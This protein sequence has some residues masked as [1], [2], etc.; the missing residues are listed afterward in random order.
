MPFQQ[1]NPY[2]RNGN[3]SGRP[4]GSR[5]KLCRRVLEDFLPIGRRVARLQSR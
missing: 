5:T 4:A 1:G 2:S 3:G